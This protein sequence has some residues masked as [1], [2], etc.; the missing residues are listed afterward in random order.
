MNGRIRVIA[1]STFREA[2]RDRVLYNLI[3]F[4]LLLVASAP[5]FG[6]ISVGIERVFLINLGLTAISLFGVVIA[7]F[8]GIGLVSKEIEKKTLYTVLSRPVRRWE[9]ITGK[10]LGLAG[11]LVVNTFFMTLGFCMALLLLTGHFG[12]AEA[13]I[14]VAIYFIILQFFIITALTLLF[15]SFSTPI[16]SAIYALAMFIVGSFAEDL[17]GFAAMAHGPQA[18]LARAASYVVPNLSVLNVITRVSHDQII[19]GSLIAT[20]TLYTLFY[21]MVVVSGSVMIFEFRNLK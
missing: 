11:T 16:E 6:Q 5:I 4:A 19:P 1:F 15:S 2:V 3:F 14:L 18:W 20:N 12:R 9:F 13:N 10:Y 21:V 7:I 8:I 17:H